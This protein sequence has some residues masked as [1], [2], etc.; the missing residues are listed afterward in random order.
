VRKTLPALAAALAAVGLI[1][2]TRLAAQSDLDAL[3][4]TVLAHRDENWKKLQQYILDEQDRIEVRG[5]KARL[6][7]VHPRRLLRQEPA[8]GERRDGVGERSA[9]VRNG[10]PQAGQSA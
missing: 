7:V 2:P 3:M 8:Q 1:I 6:H 9:A 5:R 4:K 10:F